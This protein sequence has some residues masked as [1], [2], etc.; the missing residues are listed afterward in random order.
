MNPMQNFNQIYQENYSNVF[1]LCLSYVSGNENLAEELSQEV[2]V[3][4]WQNREKFR[5]E[6]KISTWIYRIAVNTCLMHLRKIKK[7][8]EKQVDE[9]PDLSNESKEE[10]QNAKI[11]FLKACIKKLDEIGK[12]I[13]TMVL[14]EIPQS[15]IAEVTGLSNENVRVKV[16]RC[17]GRLFKCISQKEKEAN[18]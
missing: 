11:G 7:Q 8:E 17:K 6:A 16:H 1:R 4:V 5:N 14:E 15:E 12:M 2:F 3:K 18:L 13:I 9:I 10:V